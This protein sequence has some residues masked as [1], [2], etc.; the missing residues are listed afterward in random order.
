MTPLPP[1]DWDAE[2]P[3]HAARTGALAAAAAKPRNP[4]REKAVEVTEDLIVTMISFHDR[5][6][7]ARADLLD[8]E[9]MRK[10]LLAV[11]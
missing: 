6:A 11:Q 9:L 5:P 7:E 4:R 2:P 3:P 1:P 8:S 10:M